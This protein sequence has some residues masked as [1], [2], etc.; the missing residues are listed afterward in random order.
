MYSRMMMLPFPE[1]A[2]G[3][4]TL[5]MIK[6]AF[7]IHHEFSINIDAKTTEKMNS[8]KMAA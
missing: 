2:V 3:F 7:L 4:D 6:G 1:K 5:M 8:P